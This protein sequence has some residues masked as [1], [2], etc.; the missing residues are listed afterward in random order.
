MVIEQAGRHVA[1][2]D[3]EGD[4]QTNRSK[5]GSLFP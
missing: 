2:H 1:E 5:F 3:V 4:R